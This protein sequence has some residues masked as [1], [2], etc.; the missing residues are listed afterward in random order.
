MISKSPITL[1]DARQFS[2]GSDPVAW[3]R[4]IVT[5]DEVSNAG[6]PENPRWVR[7]GAQ[8]YHVH[9]FPHV[10]SLAEVEAKLDETIAAHE[11]LTHVQLRYLR[12]EVCTGSEL[13]AR[14]QKDVEYAGQ[15]PD[16]YR[17]TDLLYTGCGPLTGGGRIR[18]WAPKAYA[19]A[20]LAARD[21]A[22][23][24]DMAA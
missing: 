14:E 20:V 5:F 6:T 16:Q 10:P 19:R 1:A 3:T 8:D 22:L 11:A 21:A 23:A 7:D 2:I 13:S 24:E 18:P 4:L 9:T 15:I 12:H 17:D